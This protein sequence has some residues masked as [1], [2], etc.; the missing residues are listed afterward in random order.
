MPRR[1]AVAVLFGERALTAKAVNVATSHLCCLI[2]YAD[3]Q[4]VEKAPDRFHLERPSPTRGPVGPR[5]GPEPCG[6]GCR[7]S[8]AG[9]VH[10]ARTGSPRL[11]WPAKCWPQLD[12]AGV[13]EARSDSTAASSA[14]NGGRLPSWQ[15]APKPNRIRKVDP[16]SE[17]A[18]VLT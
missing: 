1:H 18:A 6:R 7:C 13:T 9:R 11:D 8:P 5:V 17:G 4:A 12:C 2:D 16:N 10:C 3:T 14:P 15:R